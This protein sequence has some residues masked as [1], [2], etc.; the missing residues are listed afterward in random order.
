MRPKIQLALD[1]T[2]LGFALKAAWE[3][4][5]YV[6]IIEAG[7]HLLLAEGL[8]CVSLLHKLFPEKTILADTKIIDSGDALAAAA[9]SAG[10]GVITVVGAASQSTIMKAVEA[11]HAAGKRVLLDHLSTDWDS[12]DFLT[13]SILD[14]D[15]IGLHLPK[16]LQD[17]TSL[18]TE[19]LQ[20]TLDNF[21]KPIFLAGGVEPELVRKMIGLPIEGFVVGKYLLEGSNRVEKAR[22]LKNLISQWN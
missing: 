9:C 5:D 17:S 22:K 16:D 13:K 11:A 2:D 14:V 8:Q 12:P 19:I 20:K 7:T 18:D 15:S 10:A 3:L 1:T 6:D 4:Q 21:S